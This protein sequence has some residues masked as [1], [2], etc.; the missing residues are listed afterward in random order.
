M[1][2]L[3]K[4]KKRKILLTENK[5]INLYEQ[6]LFKADG[7]EGLHLWES[8]VLF[9]RLI[10]KYKEQFSDKQII[11]LGAGCGLVG[12]TCLLY[13]KCKMLCFSDYQESVLSNLITNINLNKLEHEHDKNFDDIKEE[14]NC[15]TCYPGRYNL[16]KLDW[17]DYE[18]YKFE[19]YDLIIGSELIYSGGHIEEL[20]KVI[21]NL[22]KPDGR[23]LIT[24]P[25]KRSMTKCFLQFL[26]EN[27][28]KCS[29]KYISSYCE[30]I[31]GPVLEDQ[32]KKDKLFED[33]KSLNIILYEITRK[34]N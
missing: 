23:C 19:S 8:A 24:M 3:M 28:L 32:S 27:E 14:P 12:L 17:R 29:F 9:S 6:T 5:S 4:L 15:T 10:I 7:G 16:L 22:L 2:D 18:K 34:N 30:E 20:A 13:T 31:F 21:R 33:L 26:E 1:E 11:E 25:E